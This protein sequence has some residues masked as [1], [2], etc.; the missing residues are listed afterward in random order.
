[1]RSPPF[2]DWQGIFK[3]RIFKISRIKGP[4]S[5]CRV[6]GRNSRGIE[7]RGSDGWCWFPADFFWDLV[8]A[9]S[10]MPNDPRVGEVL[11]HLLR[12]SIAVSVDWNSLTRFYQLKLPKG[13]T[14]EA[15]HGPIAPQPL[16]SDPAFSSLAK[17]TLSGGATQYLIDMTQEV[18]FFV[19]EPCPL[20]LA[21]GGRA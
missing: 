16:F 14:I 13:E 2:P 8:D 21:R 18:R 7:G 15:I 4:L 12:D 17:R 1:M 20:W 11:R 5:L 6:T 3:N 19:D 9:C 10:T